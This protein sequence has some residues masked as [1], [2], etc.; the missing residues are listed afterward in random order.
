MTLIW[1]PSSL[2]VFTAAMEFLSDKDMNAQMTVL[3]KGIKTTFYISNLY[4][5]GTVC[6]R[7]MFTLYSFFGLV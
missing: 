7:H 6:T 4:I 3:I 5:K 1:T 2:Q